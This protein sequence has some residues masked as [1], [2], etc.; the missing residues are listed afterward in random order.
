MLTTFDNYACAHIIV[1]EGVS[2]ECWCRDARKRARAWWLAFRN[3][4]FSDF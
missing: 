2:R 3:D 4:R 1:N